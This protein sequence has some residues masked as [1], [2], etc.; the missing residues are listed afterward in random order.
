MLSLS[1]TITKLRIYWMQVFVIPPVGSSVERLIVLS[2]QALIL[3]HWKHVH[4][5]ISSQPR[6]HGM[7]Y[8]N[9]VMGFVTIVWFPHYGPHFQNGVYTYLGGYTYNLQGHSGWKVSQKYIVCYCYS[10]DVNFFQSSKLKN[11]TLTLIGMT[12]ERKKI[13]HL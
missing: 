5:Y 11:N 10:F 12:F 8:T 2:W 6:P 9:F 13:A 1:Y 3:A 4:Q 7:C